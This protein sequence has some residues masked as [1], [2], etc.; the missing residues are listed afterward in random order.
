MKKIKDIQNYSCYSRN[1]LL[2]IY[3]LKSYKKFIFHRFISIVCSHNHF[4]ILNEILKN[5]LELL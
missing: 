3:T 1:I 4:F 2:D 5:N